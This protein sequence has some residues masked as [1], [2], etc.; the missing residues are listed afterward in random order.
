MKAT[1]RWLVVFVLLCCVFCLA[2]MNAH[3]EQIGWR[4]TTA[5]VMGACGV[6]IGLL[7][8]ED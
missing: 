3:V 7:D 8:K 4:L 2:A 6:A 1:D 5:L